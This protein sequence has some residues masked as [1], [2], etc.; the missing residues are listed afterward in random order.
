MTRTISPSPEQSGELVDR[1][2][3]LHRRGLSYASD[4]PAVNLLLADLSGG[5]RQSLDA[6]EAAQAEIARLTLLVEES[7]YH[8]RLDDRAKAYHEKALAALKGSQP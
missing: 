4:K 7:L 8:L 2:W 3:N 5:I 6:L 1:L